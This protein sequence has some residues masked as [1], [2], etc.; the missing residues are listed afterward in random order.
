MRASFWTGRALYLALVAEGFTLPENCGDV[1]L[2]IPV[3]GVIALKYT[4]LMTGERLERL[5]KALIRLSKPAG[6]GA[7]CDCG[8]EDQ[9]DIGYHSSD[10][11]WRKRIENADHS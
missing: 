6:P 3:D 11:E 5:G 10:C 9:A 2:V 8:Q 1:E 4:E 7:E